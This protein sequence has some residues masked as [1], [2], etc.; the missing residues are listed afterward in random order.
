[1]LTARFKARTV[2]V[3]LDLQFGVLPLYLDLQAND[4]LI[5]AIESVETLDELAVEGWTLTHGSGLHLLGSS[6]HQL[7]LPEEV[8][9]KRVSALLALLKRAY[10][11]V[12]V[13][14][15][16][17]IDTLFEAVVETAD[18]VVVVLHP[19]LASL[20]HARSL[21]AI[22]R[23][24]YGVGGSQLCFVLNRW[25]ETLTNLNPKEIGQAL[26]GA[27]LAI[28]PRDDRRASQSLELGTPLLDSEPRAPITRE[29]L[30]L[31]SRLSGF[32]IERKGL[33]ERLISR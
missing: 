15:P 25:D 10:D 33:F 6:H 11:Q 26:D 3:D 23:G 8:S 19:S 21:L 31:T 18:R 30:A 14:L 29:L 24:R 13:D 7:V 16:R 32:E 27:S 12:V 28:I 4:G 5:Q 1:M 20:R 9:G 22:L 17:K 2:L